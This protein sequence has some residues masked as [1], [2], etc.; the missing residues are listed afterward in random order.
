MEGV[1]SAL[2]ATSLGNQL[3]KLEKYNQRTQEGTDVLY[4]PEAKAKAAGSRVP[5]PRGSNK[6]T[7]AARSRKG[8]ASE[9]VTTRGHPKNRLDG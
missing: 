7:Q 3:Q 2:L 9:K 8:M 4:S 6:Q 1:I 5:R